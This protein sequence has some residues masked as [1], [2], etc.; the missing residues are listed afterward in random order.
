MCLG[1]WI[2]RKVR[3]MVRGRGRVSASRDS[4]SG[5]PAR[6]TRR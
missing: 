2:S 1:R 6:W 5:P 4:G 3:P